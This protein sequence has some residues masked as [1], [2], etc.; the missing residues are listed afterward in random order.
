LFGYTHIPQPKHLLIE[1]GLI[2]ALVNSA[3]NSEDP[4][5]QQQSFMWLTKFSDEPSARALLVKMQISKLI[6]KVNSLPIGQDAWV[7]GVALLSALTTY[8][9]TV[10]HVDPWMIKQSIRRCFESF[11]PLGTLASVQLTS[12]LLKHGVSRDEFQFIPPNLYALYNSPTHA[13]AFAAAVRRVVPPQPRILSHT[14]QLEHVNMAIFFGLFGTL[15]GTSRWFFRSFFKGFRGQPLFKF[16]RRRGFYAGFTV[17]S[18]LM[19]DLLAQLAMATPENGYRLPWL[20]FQSLKFKHYQLKVPEYLEPRNTIIPIIE[21]GLFI[22]IA[23]YGLSR[24][25]YI[26]LPLL[27]AAF[28]K[29]SVENERKLLPSFS[30]VEKFVSRGSEVIESLSKPSEKK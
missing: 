27:L 20:E 9:D 8:E 18:L 24:Y 30:D 14:L 23:L 1:A 28:T 3:L 26:I 29:G 11:S 22:F 15:Y 19:M 21:S 17:F 16:A 2:E 10:R 4:V 5:V 12:N 25:R 7:A 6:Q 13:A